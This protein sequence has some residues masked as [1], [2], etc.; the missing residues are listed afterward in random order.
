MTMLR[1]NGA[2]AFILALETPRAYMHTFKIAILDPAN[3]PEG[4]C[5]ESYRSTVLSRLN[6]TT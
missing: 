4:W 5:F 2:D 3:E 6:I 1:M